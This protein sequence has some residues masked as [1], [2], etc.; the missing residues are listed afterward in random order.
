MN[1]PHT[2]QDHNADGVDFDVALAG[3]DSLLEM[4]TGG[5]LIC[6]PSRFPIV[7]ADPARLMAGLD[8]GH[9]PEVA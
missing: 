6:D 8:D 5:R 3:A 4:I 9:W 2:A 7:L 1:R